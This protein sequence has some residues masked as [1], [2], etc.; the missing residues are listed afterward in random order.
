MSISRYPRAGHRIAPRLL[1][2]VLCSELPDRRV[3]QSLQLCDLDESMWAR[4]SPATCKRLGETVINSIPAQLP[5]FIQQRRLPRLPDQITSDELLLEPRTRNCLTSCGLLDPPQ[6][7]A[8]VTVGEMLRIPAFGKK[9]LVDLLTS[10]ES[11]TE[12]ATKICEHTEQL[13]RKIVRVACNLQR[14]KGA[15]AICHD[16]P[17]F[18]HLIR[19]MALGAKN[20]KEAADLL[21]SGGAT[22]ASAE[23]VLR[24]I[25]N[26]IEGVRAGRHLTLEAELWEVTGELGDERDRHIIVRRLGWDGRRPRTLESVGQRYGIT[27]ERVRQICTRV[28]EIQKPQ[29]FLPALDRIIQITTA[30]APMMANELEKELVRRGLTRTT[31]CLE[32]LL[33]I[34]HGFGRK[35]P[36]AVET[37]HGHRVIVPSPRSGLLQRIHDTATAAVRRWGVSNV[38]DLAASTNTTATLVRQLLPFLPGF[39]WLDQTSGWFW[40]ADLPR[41]S[42]LTPIR[43]ILAVSPSIDVGELREGVARPH[44]RKGFA[45]PRRVLLEVCRQLAWC[46]VDGNR[47]S[48]TQLLSP[49]QML[50]D[51]ERIIFN[52]LKTHGPVLQTLELERLCLQAGINR[53]SFWIYL[54]YCPIITRYASGVYGLRGADI[55]PGLVERLIPKRP[56]KSKLLVDYGWTKDRNLR[57]IYRLSAGILSNGVVSVP[58]SLRT[59]IR[60]RFALL[61]ADNAA[62]G[63]LVAKDHT[64]WG[65]GPLFRRRGGEPGDYLSI[66]FNLSQRAAVAQVGDASLAEDT[67]APNPSSPAEVTSQLRC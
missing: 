21:V 58:A 67:E 11:V 15:S 18:G 5:T 40:I 36:F 28:E 26:L 24:Y 1:R 2:E 29:A 34:A 13:N 17:R 63:T 7:L 60:G 54:S 37:L 4:F 55:P 20:A 39:K 45:P 59:F 10:L 61:T 48:T 56:S 19:D 25:R 64:A 65:L 66:V 6:K 14:M 12:R 47:I 35:P 52:V 22:P 3:S 50:S 33:E 38:E 46:R 43:K 57:V 41:N 44:H 31:F 9:C 51:S 49:D 23:L 42:L 32:T 27:R 16:D 62:T 30:A 8:D 53:H